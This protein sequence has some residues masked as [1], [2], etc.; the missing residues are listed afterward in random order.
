[1]VTFVVED[2]EEAEEYSTTEQDSTATETVKE[3]G[4]ITETQ[5]LADPDQVVHFSD[6][7]I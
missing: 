5:E 3:S 4:T 2:L 6:R 7:L 1:M